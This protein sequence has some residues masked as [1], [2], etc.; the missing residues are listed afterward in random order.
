MNNGSTARF[1]S[2]LLNDPAHSQTTPNIF[3][4]SLRIKFSFNRSLDRRRKAQV[5]ASSILSCS[6]RSNSDRVVICGNRSP[7]ASSGSRGVAP[8]GYS[9]SAM[10]FPQFSWHL[11]EYLF[12]FR[13]HYFFLFGTR[14]LLRFQ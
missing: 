13:I 2:L 8:G 6:Q 9:N 3:S 4:C 14:K 11:L 1:F 7:S 12:Y 5:S 10:I